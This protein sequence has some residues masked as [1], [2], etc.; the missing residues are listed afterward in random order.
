MAFLS[1]ASLLH[2]LYANAIFNLVFRYA[3]EL[4]AGQVVTFYSSTYN[5]QLHRQPSQRAP[6]IIM[7][8]QLIRTCEAALEMLLAG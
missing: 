2:D 8:L 5:A 4:S 6:S 7:A 3:D 1:A